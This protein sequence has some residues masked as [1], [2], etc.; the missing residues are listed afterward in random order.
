MTGRVGVF[1]ACTTLALPPN[2]SS[3][4]IETTGSADFRPVGFERRD[5]M[6]AEAA[7]IAALE[8]EIELVIED[9]IELESLPVLASSPYLTI[10]V[11][12]DNLEDP[13]FESFDSETPV[14]IEPELETDRPRTFPKLIAIGMILAAVLVG[15]VI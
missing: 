11:T 4:L 1:A 8:V 2:M 10:A 6:S 15:S 9:L 5:N 14:D 13:W 3:Y 12:Y 7:R